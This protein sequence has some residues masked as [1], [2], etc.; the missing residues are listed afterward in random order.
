MIGTVAA[1]PQRGTAKREKAL[2]KRAQAKADRLVYQAVDARDKHRCRVCLQ[3]RA[4]DI[5]R[6]HIVARSL[7]GK[8][9]TSNVISLCAECHLIGVHLKKI[10]ISGNANERVDIKVAVA[11]VDREVTS[12]AQWAIFAGEP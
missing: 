8:T 2:N 11:N 4:S 10:V 9:T 5:Q 3:Y 12:W 6:H 7:G 1:K